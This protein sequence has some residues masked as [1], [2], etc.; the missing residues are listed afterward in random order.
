MAPSFCSILRITLCARSSP[1]APPRA[2]TSVRLISWQLASAQLSR[3]LISSS[4]SLTNRLMAMTYG[5]LN[6]RTFSMCL[7]RFSMPWSSASMFS[8][9]RS[10]LATPPCILRARIVATMTTQ[11]G[12]KPA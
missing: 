6:L 2:H 9:P 11:L 4:V 5:T 1:P 3:V 12:A 7:L 8:L 10:A